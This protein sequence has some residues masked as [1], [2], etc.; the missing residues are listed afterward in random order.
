MIRTLIIIAVASFV[1]AVVCF[2]GAAA[3]GGRELFEKGWTFSPAF[4]QQLD[5]NGDVSVQIGRDSR[6]G[7]DVTQTIAWAGGPELQI[8][9]P[10]EVSYTQ[11]AVASV[12]VSG[13]KA[14]VD[15]VILEGGRLRVKDS[16]TTGGLHM[17]YMREGLR[18]TI[19]APAVK[20]FVVNGSGDLTIADYDQPDLAIEVNGSGEV[21]VAGV[22]QSLS[23]AIAGSGEARLADLKT[24]DASI[25]V[26][27][28]GEAEV[29]ASGAAQVSIAGSGDVTLTTKPASL[30]S[31]IDGSGDL[32]LPQ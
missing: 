25:A 21:E 29:S 3:I 13:P 6:H 19:V 7:P 10:A 23:L 2:S 17:R 28:S 8:D 15:R 12:T 1:L 16:E 27:G 20:R 9:V 24:R 14:L 4:L 31:N 18:V 22:T 5:E 26:A 32:H 30:S 11:G